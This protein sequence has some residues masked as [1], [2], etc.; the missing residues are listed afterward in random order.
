MKVDNSPIR[1]TYVIVV[2]RLLST[3]EYL[4][5]ELG[6]KLYLSLNFKIHYI[7]MS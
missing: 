7:K 3:T 5:I 4:F 1:R 6:G 2:F